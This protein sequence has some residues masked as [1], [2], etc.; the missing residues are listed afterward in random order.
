MTMTNAQPTV[1]Y[2]ALA[3]DELIRLKSFLQCASMVGGPEK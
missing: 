3:Y 2:R 1:K